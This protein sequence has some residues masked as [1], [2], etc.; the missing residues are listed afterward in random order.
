MLVN[1]R[2]FQRVAQYHTKYSRYTDIPPDHIEYKEFWDN[3]IEKCLHGVKIGD[4]YITGYHYFYLNFCKIMRTED[5]YG[6]VHNSK[7]KYVIT[8]KDDFFPAF[9]DGD[10]QYFN[11]VERCENPH[12]PLIDIRGLNVLND[13]NRKH[14]IVLKARGKGYS[15]KGGAM[16]ARNYY[17]IRKSKSYAIASENE[18]L[19]KDGILTKAWSYLDF[20]DQNTAWRKRRLKNAPMHK[21]AGY[22]NTIN[23]VESDA[24]YMSQIIGVTLK[25]DVQKA[26]GKRGKLI[27]WEEAGKFPGFK[28]AWNIARPSVEDRDI[29]TGFMIGQGTGGTEGANFEDV[30][31]MFYNPNAYN[32]VCVEN[33]WDEGGL[34][35]SCGLFI[36]D[37]I[38]AGSFMDDEGNSHHAEAKAFEENQREI[39]AANA[40]SPTEVDEHAA[41]HPFTPREACLQTSG[42]IF[43]K[44][45]LQSQLNA[46]K[47]NR[48]LNAGVPIDLEYYFND[49][50]GR[51]DVRITDNPDIIEKLSP[52]LKFPTPKD[53]GEGCIMM[54]EAPFTRG[55][56]VPDDLYYIAND[57][58]AQSGGQSLGSC[59]VYKRVNKWSSPDDIIVAEYH[60]RPASTE[61]Y[62]RRMFKLAEFYNAKIGFENDRGDVLSN[63]KLMKK[64]H[65]LEPQ[66]TLEY[67]NDL[68][69]SPVA[70]PYGMH[71]TESRK[72]AGAGYLNT[73][74]R[75]LR[76]YD[77]N[78][79]AILNLN[80]IR[81]PATLEELIA[82][83]YKGNFDRV[84]QMIIA[85][86]YEKEMDFTERSIGEQEREDDFFNRRRFFGGDEYENGQWATSD[87]I[88]IYDNYTGGH[89]LMY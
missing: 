58:F 14:L 55:G 7:E 11:V 25:N 56:M 79:K 23:G 54:Y 15:F 21:T 80:M 18:F 46:V 63:A 85:M 72:V 61:E 40:T 13:G 2:E 24:G 9:W 3:E 4:T 42:N 12:N 89:T 65:L 29:V 31:E 16:M 48:N 83:N 34:G 60:A 64:V 69:D 67:N 20:I 36:P 87:E 5:T 84:S 33:F 27:V 44:L 88:N 37:Y 32:A 74:L 50:L 78:G 70:R 1:T 68:K 62:D 10:H 17:L 71:M 76:G 30:E 47:T 26:R 39:I 41:E 77:T 57:P 53:A 81:D 66:F 75:R 86:F 6:T 35:T 49:K 73:W 82:F 59:A 19:T 8:E 52:I 45:L 38:N 43:P 28:R 22:K 51:E